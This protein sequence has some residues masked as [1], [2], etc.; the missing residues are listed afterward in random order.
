M[1]LVR[2]SDG[3]QERC[4]GL[5]QAR[6]AWAERD[7]PILI[8]FAHPE[9]ESWVIA[10]FEPQGPTE[11]SALEGL[12]RDLGFDPRLEAHRL[13]GERDAKRVLA[14]LTHGDPDRE[15]ACW[16]ECGLDVLRDHGTLTGLASYLEEVRRL[17]VP[18]FTEPRSTG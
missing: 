16:V 7:L 10:G 3:Q 5:E 15:S 17:L 18:V 2:D 11:T 8:A 12:R 6:A 14:T 1:V 13:G 4:R 9:R